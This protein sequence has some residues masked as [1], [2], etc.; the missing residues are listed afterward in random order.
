MDLTFLQ[1]KTIKILGGGRLY[2]TCVNLFVGKQLFRAYGQSKYTLL[3]KD[4]KRNVEKD[5]NCNT[6]T[7]YLKLIDTFFSILL[8]FFCFPNAE[9]NILSL[10]K[11]NIFWV[12][13]LVADPLPDIQNDNFLHKHGL[14]QKK[15]TQKSL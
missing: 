12:C 10:P 3:L 13:Q 14:S 7:K 4:L 9:K 2:H 5:Y 1:L 8:V 15:F 11:I 6:F